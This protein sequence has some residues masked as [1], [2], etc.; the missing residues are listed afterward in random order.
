[1]LFRSGDTLYYA[2]GTTLSKLGIGANKTIMTSTGSA[3]QWSASLD[4]TQGGTGVTSYTAGDL[5]YYASGSAL[6]KLGIGTA[7]YV[8]TSSG[9]A[10]QWTAQSGLSVGTALNH[11]SNATTGVMQITGPSAATTRVMTI[12]DANFT[13]ARTDAGQTFTGTNTFTSDLTVSSS[14]ATTLNLYLT[15]NKAA[16]QGDAY[17]NITKAANGNSNGI[18]LYTGA[19]QKWIFGTGI[20]AVND[21]FKI[22]N[23]STGS[24]A[25][26]IPI[27]GTDITFNTGNLIQGTAAKGINFTANTPASGKTSQLL[28]WYEIGRAHV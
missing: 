22:Y 25:L 1:M 23:G 26:E 8:L 15:N 7:N 10:P 9:T 14:S 28:N 27:G 20:T 17:F 5:P 4:T 3:P 16:G 13:V 24:V 11:L 18:Q 19:S 2:S 21:N 6:S 12:P